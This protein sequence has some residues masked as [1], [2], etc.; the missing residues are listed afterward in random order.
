MTGHPL[1]AEA[2]V[3]PQEPNWHIHYCPRP[4][5]DS[6]GRAICGAEYRCDQPNCFEAARVCPICALSG[7]VRWDVHLD[8]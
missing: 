2:S 8:P 5:E 6:T 7:I 1:Q 4:L 3:D